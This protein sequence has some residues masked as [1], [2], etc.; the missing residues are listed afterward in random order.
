MIR[1]NV[2]EDALRLS[3]AYER[4]ETA[5]A[6]LTSWVSITPGCTVE[7][8]EELGTMARSV[9]DYIVNEPLPALILRNG[10]STAPK[11]IPTL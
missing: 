11:R 4:R 10:K 6:I 5:K 2:S 7:K 8:A 9:A 3:L 1:R